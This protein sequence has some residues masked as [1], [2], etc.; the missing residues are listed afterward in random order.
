MFW[1]V[2]RTMSAVRK[3]S[4]MVT[5]RLALWGR[6]QYGYEKE[7]GMGNVRV[8]ESTLEPLDGCSHDGVLL[9][10][11]EVTGE[12]ANT[13]GTHRVALVSHGGG[14]NLVLLE[15]LLDLLEVGEKTDVGS[16]LV[17]G[18]TEGREG[19]E[20]VDVDLARVSLSS[21]GVSMLEAGELS[22]E[23]VEL[24]NL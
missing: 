21:D 7:I 12:G 22:D 16:D 4:G 9:D 19:T 23:L 11:H 17:R 2:V 15:R 1:R 3:A 5:R 8:V 6:G 14:S 20:D 10:D 24:L 18:G 13:L